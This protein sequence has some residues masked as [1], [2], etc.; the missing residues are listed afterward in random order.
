MALEEG[1]DL[2]AH[3]NEAGP[4]DC[5]KGSDKTHEVQSFAGKVLR[6]QDVKEKGKEQGGHGCQGQDGADLGCIPA[7]HGP[8]EAAVGNHGIETAVGQAECLE[9]TGQVQKMGRCGERQQTQGNEGVEDTQK[10]LRR[11][12][13]EEHLLG[14]AKAGPDERG[15]KAD[16]HAKAAAALKV[17]EFAQILVEEEGKAQQENRDAQDLDAVHGLVQDK[18]AAQHEQHGPCLGDNLAGRGREK[19]HGGVEKH[20]VAAKAESC[21]KDEQQGLLAVVG[22]GGDQVRDLLVVVA[23][24]VHERDKEAAFGLVGQEEPHPQGNGRE[25][26]PDNGKHVHTGRDLLEGNRQRAPEGHCGQGK[27]ETLV[28][29]KCLHGINSLGLQTVG[30]RGRDLSRIRLVRTGSSGPEEKAPC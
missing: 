9:G 18:D 19:E 21:N 8:S 6:G 30:K 2:R 4:K 26:Q 5:H 11:H 29:C 20:E 13:P 25:A 16:K 12:F 28:F 15:R 22:T 27:A 10:T 14:Y 17:E 1:E 24:P 3:G 7:G 23:Q